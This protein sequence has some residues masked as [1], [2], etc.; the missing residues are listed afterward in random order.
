[1]KW[2]REL[3]IRV[4]ILVAISVSAMGGNIDPGH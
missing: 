4:T 2:T 3:G 1:L